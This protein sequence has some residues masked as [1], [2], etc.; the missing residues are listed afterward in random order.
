MGN[1]IHYIYSKDRLKALLTCPYYLGDLSK[2]TNIKKINDG[3]ILKEFQSTELLLKKRLEP[4]QWIT[5]TCP[6]CNRFSISYVFQFDKLLEEEKEMRKVEE[7]Q[8]SIIEEERK[9][10]E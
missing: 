7:A 5:V 2:D 6:H 4:N 10:I 9:E 3:S 1:I 8:L